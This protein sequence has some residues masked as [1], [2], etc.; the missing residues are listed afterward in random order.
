MKAVQVGILALLLVIAGLLATVVFQRSGESAA[1]AAI[2]ELTPIEE[3]LAALAPPAP[4][5]EPPKPAL[6]PAPPRGKP[7]PARAAAP[8]PPA[9]PASAPIASAAPEAP[10][11]APDH[12]GLLARTPSRIL[13]PDTTTAPP[14]PA[15]RKVTVPAGHE[16]KVRLI[17]TISTNRHQPGDSFS[18]SLDE[19][20]VIDDLVIAETNARV[21][22]RVIDSQKGGRVKGRA[23]ISLELVRLHTE[24]GQQIEISTSTHARQAQ[25][26]AK[27]DAKRVSIMTGIGAA[28]GAIAGGGKGAAIGAGVGAG[29]G[30]GTV[31][32]TRGDAVVIASE[33]PLVFRLTE[34]VDIVESL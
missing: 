12:A 29:A 31:A 5:P 20:L 16:L 22:G 32:A 8:A 17:S 10:K 9:K 33:T 3:P 19:P 27:S 15:P 18:A 11:I 26:T 34:S 1:D 30:G 2:P 28:V 25:S 7:A 21:E 14:P 6:A 4:E 23:A 24:D 13:K